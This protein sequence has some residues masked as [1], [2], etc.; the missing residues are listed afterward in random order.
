MNSPPDP[1]LKW[2]G[3]KRWL[4]A[5]SQLRIPASYKKYIEPFLGSG[6]MYFRLSPSVALLSDLNPELIETYKAVR[7][8]PNKI[9]LLLEEHQRAHSRV[10]YYA[11]R[12]SRP[13]TVLGRAAR[14]IYLNR[15]CWNGLYRVNQK[16][17]FNV[18]I[19]TK[20]KVAFETD[21]FLEVASLLASADIRSGDFEQYVDRACEGDLLFL[22]PPYTA[23][24]NLNGFLKYNEKIFSWSDQ[25]RLRNAALRA[26][27][28]GAYVMV[29]NADHPSVRELYEKPFSFV[30]VRRASVLAAKAVARKR[31]TEALFTA[32]F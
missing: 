16:G 18:P 10:Y 25:V 30:E 8:F 4:V 20:T 17:R 6:A 26:A 2:V 9:L 14:F 29:T 3:G 27:D 5:S 21:H 24:H 28:R 13:S 15:T 1:F 11:M 23:N 31:T 22:D 12:S 7:A 32:N 19:G